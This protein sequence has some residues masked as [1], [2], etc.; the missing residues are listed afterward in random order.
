MI[1]GY[2]ATT[3]YSAIPD[4]VCFQEAAKPIS[5]AEMRREAAIRDLAFKR[6]LLSNADVQNGSF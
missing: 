4:K 5:T 1:S 2:G 6:Q 3:T